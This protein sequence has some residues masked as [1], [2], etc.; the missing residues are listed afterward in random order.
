MVVKKITRKETKETVK[1]ELL[2]THGGSKISNIEKFY[3]VITL[4]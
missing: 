4:F 3:V 1:E 2:K